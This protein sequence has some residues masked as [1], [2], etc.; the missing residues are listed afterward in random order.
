M[1][2]SIY[3]SLINANILTGHSFTAKERQNDIA[4]FTTKELRN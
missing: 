2:V 4:K 1:V 3:I